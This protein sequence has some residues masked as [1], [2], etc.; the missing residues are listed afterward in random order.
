VFSAQATQTGP[1]RY[2]VVSIVAGI[3]GP[4]TPKLTYIFYPFSYKCKMLW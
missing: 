1:A 2:Y 3:E 4:R